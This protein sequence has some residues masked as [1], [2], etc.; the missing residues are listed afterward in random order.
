MPVS[1]HKN[2]DLRHYPTSTDLQFPGVR[3][4]TCGFKKALHAIHKPLAYRVGNSD[5]VRLRD[6]VV[7]VL[8]RSDLTILSHPMDL[9]SSLIHNSGVP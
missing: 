4:G 1:F 6:R 2:L 9:S 8:R 5:V 7:S 3:S